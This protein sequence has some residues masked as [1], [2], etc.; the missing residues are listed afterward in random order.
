MGRFLTE[1]ELRDIY[2]TAV[3]TSL[4]ASLG[5]AGS[6]EQSILDAED[7][8]MSYLRGHTDLPATPETTSRR[9]KVLVG[10]LALYLLYQGKAE[11]PIRVWKG[12][13]I[14]VAGLKG[15]QRGELSIAS[16]ADLTASIARP[17]VSVIKRDPRDESRITL[18]SMRDWG[19]R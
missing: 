15:I 1:A 7:E 13:E 17:A 19:H 5:S 2:G 8:A 9:L 14:A 16:P 12:R 10:Q 18:E 4:A 11:T 6:V 3:V